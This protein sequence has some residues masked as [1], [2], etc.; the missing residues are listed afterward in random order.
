MTQVGETIV[1]VENLVR[2]HIL[3][4]LN[5]TLDITQKRLFLPSLRSKSAASSSSDQTSGGLNF[6]DL[7]Q[8]C[9]HI[10]FLCCDLRLARR[11]S[12]VELLDSLGPLEP[13]NLHDVYD[14]PS[15]PLCPHPLFTPLHGYSIPELHPHEHHQTVEGT[16]CFTVRY[17]RVPAAPIE[18]FLQNLSVDEA[19]DCNLESLAD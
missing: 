14:T 2:W 9:H 7:I 6:I 11:I 1:L 8:F 15:A 3:R 4:A 10:D 16:L 17:V 5:L 12:F 19:A 18:V 13:H